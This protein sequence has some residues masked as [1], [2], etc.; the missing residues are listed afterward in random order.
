MSEASFPGCWGSPVSL[1][2]GW[3]RAD[4]SPAAAVQSLLT[5]DSHPL[6]SLLPELSC[7]QGPLLDIQT[8]REEPS[9]ISPHNR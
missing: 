7:P 8:P 6:M 4:E 2:L 5:D 3:V 9:P 1:R